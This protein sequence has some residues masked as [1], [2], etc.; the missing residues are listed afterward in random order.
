MIRKASLKD[1][2]EICSIYNYHVANT[3]VTFEEDPVNENEMRQRIEDIGSKFP[4]LVYENDDV[5]A[6]YAYASQWR[7]R[8]AYRFAAETTVYIHEDFKGRGVGTALY[9]R[10]IEEMKAL[11]FRSLIGGVSLPND[12]SIA[13]HE[14]FNFKKVAHFEQV[15][16]KLNHWIDV[17]Y[18]QLLLN[19]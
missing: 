9:A 16:F 1:T 15:G 11:S 17:G 10:L 13:L 12:A 6:G 19:S 8:S 2:K 18:W 7:T 4:W 14:K 3:I 5:I